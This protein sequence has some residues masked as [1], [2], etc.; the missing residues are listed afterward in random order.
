[1]TRLVIVLLMLVS[2]ACPVGAQ[3]SAQQVTRCGV[4]TAIGDGWML[5]A[6]LRRLGPR[7]AVFRMQP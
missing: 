4:P 7:M 3:N 2:L 1:M 6:A 5:A